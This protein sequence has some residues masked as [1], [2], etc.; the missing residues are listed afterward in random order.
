MTWAPG[1]HPLGLSPDGDELRIQVW[2]VANGH[3]IEYFSI[4]L[5]SIIDGEF[6]EV[7]RYDNS[8]GSYPHRDILNWDGSTREK[9]R[10]RDGLTATTAFREAFDTMLRHWQQYLRDYLRRRP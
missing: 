9:I 8:H 7:A 4:Q 2:H 1:E 5:V 10:M 3:E 6:R